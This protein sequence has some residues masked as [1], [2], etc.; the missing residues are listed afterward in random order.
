[1]EGVLGLSVRACC[2]HALPMLLSFLS[3]CPEHGIG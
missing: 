3:M 1:M 2:R